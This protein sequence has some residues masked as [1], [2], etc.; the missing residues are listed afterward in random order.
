MVGLVASGVVHE[1]LLGGRI[2]DATEK[3]LHPDEIGQRHRELLFSVR[4]PETPDIGAASDFL[5]TSDFSRDQRVP[6]CRRLKQW[7]PD[8]RLPETPLGSHT[9][10]EGARGR[11]ARRTIGELITCP[12]CLDMWVATGLVAGFI[13]LPRA[14]RL[15]VDTLVVL[16]GADVLQLGYSWLQ[17]QSS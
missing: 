17:E 13:Y 6:A 8:T 16:A 10:M 12:F 5:E 3:L 11:G 4:I 7:C 1:L 15:A 9:R 14:T 2:A